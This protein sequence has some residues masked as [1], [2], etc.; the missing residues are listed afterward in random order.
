MFSVTNDPLYA[1]VAVVGLSILLIMVVT[2]NVERYRIAMSAEYNLSLFHCSIPA[3]V[4]VLYEKN[5]LE[6]TKI[7]EQTNKQ[8][9]LSI[10]NIEFSLQDMCLFQPHRGCLWCPCINPKDYATPICRCSGEIARLCL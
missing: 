10:C 8:T 2:V 7:N 4:K 1:P 6:I 3:T 5:I 9:S